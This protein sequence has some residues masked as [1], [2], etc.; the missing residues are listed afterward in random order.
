[1]TLKT[2]Q[3]NTTETLFQDV[4]TTTTVFTPVV[5]DEF[6]AGGHASSIF[7]AIRSLCTEDE[8]DDEG[9]RVRPSERALADIVRYL[10]GATYWVS[11]KPAPF[12]NGHVIDDNGGVRIEW[13]TGTK[14]VTLSVN[15]DD[16]ARNFVFHKLLDDHPGTLEQ[17]PAPSRLG[18]LLLELHS[19][20]A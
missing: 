12:P 3:D 2:E 13:W 7:E 8:V 15:A 5:A 1:M 11:S 17:T 9:I 20:D 6:K 16:A 14:C 19:Q 4:D 10:E 18:M